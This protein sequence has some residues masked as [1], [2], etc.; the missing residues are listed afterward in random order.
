[1]TILVFHCVYGNFLCRVAYISYKRHGIYLSNVNIC[2]SKVNNVVYIVIHCQPK[3]IIMSKISIGMVLSQLIKE[4]NFSAIQLSERMGKSRQ[5]IYAD[6]KRSSMRDDMIEEYA[7]ALE[8]DK[9]FIYD[10]MEGIE[11][12]DSNYLIEHL[13]NLE[14]QFKRLLNQIDVKDRQIEGLQKTVEVLLGKSNPVTDKGKVMEMY[15]SL[16][17]A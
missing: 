7:K 1:M 11:S 16:E 8:I 3:Y 10:R 2:I 15:K 14:E 9:Q 6:L 4:K 17:V 13:S 12:T 5:V